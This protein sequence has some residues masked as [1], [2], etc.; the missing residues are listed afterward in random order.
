MEQL[1]AQLVQVER[2]EET[3]HVFRVIRIC[4][5]HHAVAAFYHIG[6]SEAG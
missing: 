2:L 6:R 3:H 5:P 4:R 1:D